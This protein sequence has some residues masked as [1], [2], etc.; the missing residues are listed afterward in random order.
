MAAQLSVPPHMLP[1]PHINI[2]DLLKFPLPIQGL[3][4]PPPLRANVLAAA[5]VDSEPSC[6]DILHIVTIE[7]P[8][9]KLLTRMNK[10]LKKAVGEGAKAMK[11]VHTV[12]VRNETLPLWIVPYWQRVGAARERKDRWLEVERFLLR[13]H[14]PWLNPRLEEGRPPVSSVMRAILEMLYPRREDEE[15][16]GFPDPQPF[17]RLVTFVSEDW[18]STW[19]MDLQLALLRQ[20]LARAGKHHVYVPSAY[21]YR[22]I[23]DAFNDKERYGQPE[24]HQSVLRMGRRVVL[25]NLDVASAANV[26]ENHWI[27]FALTRSN[28]T[29][30]YGDPMGGPFHQQFVLVMNW[31]IEF[32]LSQTFTWGRMKVTNQTDSFSC[33]ILGGNGLRHFYSGDAYPLASPEPRGVDAERAEV[34]LMVLLQDRYPDSL[35]KAARETTDSATASREHLDSVHVSQGAILALEEEIT[36][37]LQLGPETRATTTQMLQDLP[38][39]SLETLVFLR[40]YGPSQYALCKEDLT[41]QNILRDPHASEDELLESLRSAHHLYS[42]AAREDFRRSVMRG[43]SIFE[44]FYA[45]VHTNIATHAFKSAVDP[46]QSMPSLESLGPS[47]YERLVVQLAGNPRLT[48]KVQITDHSVDKLSATLEAMSMKEHEGRLSAIQDAVQMANVLARDIREGTL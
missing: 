17:R 40:L 23:V 2:H 42:L 26:D 33:G 29:L 16:Q 47:R 39:F 19:H 43:A 45:P 38:A 5:F 27:V 46:L 28:N 14:N 10:A 25:L 24:H 3:G 41:S 13:V 12:A 32:H 4:S 36:A 22:S 34:L 11:V 44:R 21:M 30:Y 18:L 6:T 48:N 7:V 37:I 9:A 1:G 20:E 15:V 8:V 31:W 35:T